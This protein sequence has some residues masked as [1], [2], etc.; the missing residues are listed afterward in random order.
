METRSNGVQVGGALMG[1]GPKKSDYKPNESDVLNARISMQRHTDYKQKYRPMLLEMRDKAQSGDLT[2]AARAR[3]GADTMQALHA[4]VPQLRA[5]T[6]VDETTADTGGALTS[7]L[8]KA[9]AAGAGAQNDMGAGVLSAANREGAHAQAGL[10]QIARINTS[11]AL[12]RASDKMERQRQNY[13]AATELG[14]AFIA[15]AG[16]NVASGGTIF[17][18]NAGTVVDPDT[19]KVI[20]KRPD[21]LAHRARIGTGRM[22]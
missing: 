20:F 18:P 3:A 12:A 17:T 16:R 21:D 22:G 4:D 6:T 11:D 19:G 10:Q 13:A 9:T 1:S 8:Q 5:A 14:T 15:N 7:Q 2:K